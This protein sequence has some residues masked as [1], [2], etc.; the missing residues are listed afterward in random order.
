MAL[1]CG[2]D[3]GTSATKVLLCTAGRQGAGHGERGVSGLHAQARLVGAGAGGL[4]E[5]DRRRASPPPARR[6]R[7]SPR[8][9]TGIGLSGQMHGSVFVDKAGKSLRRAL[10]WN[11]QRTAAE[12]A[13]IEQR[14]GGRKKLIGMVSNVALTGF[15]APK[16]L[17]VR[18]HDPKTYEQDVQDPAAQGLHPA[19]ADRRVRQRGQRRGRHAAAGHQEARLAHAACSSKLE[20]DADLMPP[21]VRVAGGDRQGHRR[22]SPS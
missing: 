4:V 13:E 7:S 15:T 16:I 8:Q 21:A 1:L 18:K 6:P 12:C 10:L 19:Q 20:I 5:G 9:I 14:A 3:I 22:R 2:I 11:D 17:W